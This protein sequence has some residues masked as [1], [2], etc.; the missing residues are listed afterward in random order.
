MR[1]VI[2]V[3]LSTGERRHVEPHSEK[4]RPGMVRE[5]LENNGRMLRT[6]EGTLVNVDEVVEAELLFDY[7]KRI[8]PRP[9]SDFL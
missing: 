1:D 4:R 2:R 3:T 5:L 9:G 6:L 7:D 8:D